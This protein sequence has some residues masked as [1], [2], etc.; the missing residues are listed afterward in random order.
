MDSL[1]ILTCVAKIVAEL[2]QTLLYTSFKISIILI[3][4]GKMLNRI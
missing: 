4:E 2:F 1:F 3:W